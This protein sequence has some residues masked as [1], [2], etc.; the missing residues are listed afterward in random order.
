MFSGIVE[1]L[2]HLRSFQ[3][4]VLQ[5][6]AKKVLKGTK[7]GDSIAVNGAC[8]TVTKL[9][10]RD[11]CV[12]VV[13][14]TLRRTNLGQLAV[15]SP[16]NLERAMA[17]GDRVGGHLVQ[18][19]VDGTAP[20][21]SIKPDGDAVMLRFRL[22]ARLARYVVEKGFITVDGASLTVVGCGPTWF[23]VTLIPFTRAH[24]VLGSKSVGDQVNLEVD[25]LAKYAERLAQSPRKRST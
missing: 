6:S 7:L 23:T 10:A 14:E 25:M 3:D 2:G 22:P 9:T 18:G 4:G 17:Y 13:P 15:G 19:H 12:N 21:T 11:F 24:T 1:E 5:I 16:V 8:L 20:I